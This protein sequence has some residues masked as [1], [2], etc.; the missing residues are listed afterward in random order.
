VFDRDNVRRKPF[1]D[2]EWKQRIRNFGN[3]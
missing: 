3:R 1:D 2:K